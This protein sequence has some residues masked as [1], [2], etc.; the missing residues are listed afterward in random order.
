MVVGVEDG[1][2][3]A[4]IGDVEMAC[5][6]VKTAGHAD[7]AGGSDRAR[8]PRRHHDLRGDS[9][10]LRPLTS[11]LGEH[12]EQVAGDMTCLTHTET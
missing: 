9:Q 7:V 8:V 3:A 10:H 11:E 4:K 2:G 12:W 1:H 5:V 6:L